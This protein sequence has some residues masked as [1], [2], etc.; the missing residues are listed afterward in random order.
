MALDLNKMNF[1]NRLDAR[2]R[3]F[4]L[5]A[6]V[7]GLGILVYVLVSV[8]SSDSSA[9]GPSSVAGAP[10]NLSPT[11]GG[12][13]TPEYLRALQLANEKKAEAARMSGTSAVPT[14]LNVGQSG[15]EG[16]TVLC[17][18]DNVNIK[19]TLDAWVSQSKIKADVAAQLQDLAAKN[20]SVAEFAGQL[21]ALV[22]AQKLTPD[23]ARRLLEEYTKQHG[24]TQLQESAKLMDSLIQSGE[25]PLDV[26]N[27]LLAAQKRNISTAEYSAMLQDLVR[28]GKISPATAQK[29]LSQYT[30][31]SAKEVAAQNISA[32]DKMA[33]QGEITK[34][35]AK[36]LG[37]MMARGVPVDELEAKLQALVAAGQLTP[38]AAK[39]IL[40]EYKRQ[41]L[42]LGNTNL[43]DGLKKN[44]EDAAYSALGAMLESGKISKETSAQLKGLMDKNVSIDDYQRALDQLVKD[45]KLTPEAAQELSAR[46]KKAK[47]LRDLAANL[48]AL[49]GNN[50]SPADY[51]NALK[52][53]VT[54]GILSPDEAAQA[55]K[56]YQIAVTKAP[57]STGATSGVSG[58]FERLQR[59]LQN[60]PSGQGGAI[61]GASGPGS[62]SVPFTQAQ[63]QAQKEVA[64]EAKK[65]MQEKVASMVGQSDAL[66]VAWAPP[67]MLH[68]DG[69]L[70]GTGSSTTTKTTVTSNKEGDASGGTG[71][72]DAAVKPVIIKGGSIIFA[73]LDTAI[74]SD[75]PDSP[76][77]ATVVEGKYK[78][79]K[80]LGKIVTTKGVSGQL[81]RVSLNFTLMNLDEWPA[82]RPITAYGVDPD[83]AR[84][85]IASEVDYHY[86]TRFGAMI[87]TSFLQGYGNAV[88]SS[89]GTGVT[90]AFG[91]SSTNPQLSPS[92]KLAVAIGNM[93]K[94]LGDATKNY[95]N[96]PPTVRVDSG[97]GL[98][99]LFMSD[100]T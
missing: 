59:N 28:Q 70:E 95:I 78:G 75:Y 4:V 97:V 53:A 25:L 37:D 49:Q 85:V 74:N 26:A 72:N 22:K 68:R 24:S 60:T 57:V 36:T 93:G 89:G 15:G 7:I 69:N 41:K 8:M 63:L 30:A 21:D 87:A 48:A 3:V 19:G 91:T 31:Q 9:V 42:E 38:A 50:A 45:N 17:S 94:A 96:Q 44:A 61:G 39:K 13:M 16:C 14:L 54:A 58:D 83:T 71:A 34:D 52:A 77:L 47:D 86:R 92:A 82:S 5:F 43:V 100:V 40:D 23:Q 10:G 98:G 79:A 56:E 6:G 12:K 11:P 35:V 90:S 76:V 62:G 1:F 18:D 84:T 29:L 20:V 67:N 88:S 51:A 99:I 33:S 46:Y 64:E 32:L 66:L 81:D 2:A 80:L 27:T 73:V 55:L 65:R